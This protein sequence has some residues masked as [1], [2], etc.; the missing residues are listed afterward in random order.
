M[1]NPRHVKDGPYRGRNRA[2]MD[3]EDARYQAALILSGSNLT[4]SSISG[5]SYQFGP[6]Q[7]WTLVEWGMQIQFAYNQIAPGHYADVPRP[8]GALRI[9]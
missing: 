1:P 2:Q 9:A 7:D 4:G 6:R 3:T 8:S 5:Q